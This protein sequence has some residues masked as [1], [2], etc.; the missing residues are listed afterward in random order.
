MKLHVTF[1]IDAETDADLADVNALMHPIAENFKVAIS[2]IGKCER[3]WI[4]EVYDGPVAEFG[5][6]D[7]GIEDIVS[8]ATRNPLTGRK[9]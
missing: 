8:E 7:H 3:Y 5:A 4:K 2:P 1:E 6:G 9:P